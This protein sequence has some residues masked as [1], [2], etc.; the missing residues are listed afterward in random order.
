MLDVAAL[1]AQFNPG[2]GATNPFTSLYLLQVI[3]GAVLPDARS[4][5]SLVTL[6]C[7]SFA[8]LIVFYRPLQLPI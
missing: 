4:T 7:A 8:G 1:T 6:T 3:L 5:W 2:G